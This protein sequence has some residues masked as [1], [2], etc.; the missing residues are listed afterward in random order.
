MLTGTVTAVISQS[1]EGIIAS[2]D[3]ICSPN[4][5]LLTG[6]D[7]LN[8]NGVDVCN[9]GTQPYNYRGSWQCVELV[10][11]LYMSKGWITSPWYGNGNTIAEPDN[12]P[13]G[14]IEQNQGFISY[15]GPGDV[16]SFN[17]NNPGDHNPD[18][19]AAIVDTVY[20][21]RFGA[22]RQSKRWN[23]CLYLRYLGT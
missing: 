4:G 14:L 20:Y 22:T 21:R 10:N 11:R 1:N 13:P 2:A 12:V 19:H 8:G 6:S 7:W 23:H 18:G 3:A 5:I 9:T 15:L 16:V 17:D